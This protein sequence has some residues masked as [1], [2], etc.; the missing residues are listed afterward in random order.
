MWRIQPHPDHIQD[1]DE[2]Q[3]RKAAFVRPFHEALIECLPLMASGIALAEGLIAGVTRMHCQL[4]GMLLYYSACVSHDGTDLSA[5]VNFS[6]SL[7]GVSQIE[8]VR[9]VLFHG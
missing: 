8:L 2:R 5:H 6:D 7:Q 1:S 3:M 4:I 9:S